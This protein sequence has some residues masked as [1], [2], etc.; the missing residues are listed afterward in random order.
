MNKKEISAQLKQ[1]TKDELIHI[2][3][4]YSYSFLHIESAL[5]AIQAQ[6]VKKWMEEENRL[7]ELSK[8]A[9][10]VYKKIIEPYEGQPLAKVPQDVAKQASEAWNEYCRLNDEWNRVS[11]KISRLLIKEPKGG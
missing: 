2:I 7:S 11:K 6:R 1:C 8:S 10:D 9:F 4:N 3:L 5:I